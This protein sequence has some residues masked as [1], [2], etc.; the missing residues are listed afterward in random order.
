MFT[1]CDNPASITDRMTGGEGRRSAT[2]RSCGL[3][4]G[5]SA[6]KEVCIRGRAAYREDGGLNPE[7]RGVFIQGCLHP[8]GILPCYLDV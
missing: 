2:S 6:S 5:G 1:F 7:W 4:Q 8:T 3:L